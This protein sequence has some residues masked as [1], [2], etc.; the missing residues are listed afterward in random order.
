MRR[1]ALLIYGAAVTVLLV[2]L[3]RN[4]LTG[5]EGALAQSVREIAMGM[6]VFAGEGIFAPQSAAN[7]FA[8]KIYWLWSCAAGVSEWSLRL[9]TAFFALLL[10][11][12]TMTLAGKIFDRKTAFTAG[13]LLLGSYGFIHWGRHISWHMMSA[14]WVIWCTVLMLKDEPGRL[15]MFFQSMVFCTGILLW[16]LYFFLPVLAVMIFFPPKIRPLPLVSA[17]TVS[18]AAVFLLTYFPGR[19]WMEQLSAARNAVSWNLLESFRMMIYPGGGVAWWQGAENLPRLLLPWIPVSIAAV[20]GMCLRYRELPENTRKLLLT[21]GVM[22]LLLGVFPGKKWQYA[23]PLLPFFIVLTAGG[24]A[25]ECGVLRWN[26]LAEVVMNWVFSLTGAITAA[27]IVTYPLWDMLLKVSPPLVLMLPVPAMGFLAIGLLVFDTGPTSAEEKISGMRGAWSGYIL[28]GVVL[29]TAL[30]GITIP[31]LT[32]FRTGRPFWK[33]CGVA[34]R[35]IPPEKV[36][37]AGHTPQALAY[38]YMGSNSRFPVVT[39]MDKLA[40]YCDALAGNEAVAVIAVNDFETFSRELLKVSWAVESTPLVSEGVPLRLP[41]GHDS[42]GLAMYKLKR[43]SP[44][45]AAELSP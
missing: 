33:K 17:V 45:E 12:G 36:I 41:G 39:A 44:G 24:I 27:V 5:S 43:L 21:A 38:F 16:G 34:I 11:S 4:A 31:S 25:G 15:R 18:I 8:G 32:K 26:R 40:A 22:F 1:T 30:W 42:K 20:A 13:W 9:L 29:S 19:S 37:F 2:L 35:N 28:A 14:T 23:L 6:D 7:L 10:F 3:G